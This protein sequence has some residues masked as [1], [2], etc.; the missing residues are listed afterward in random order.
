MRSLNN[1][2]CRWLNLQWLRITIGVMMLIVTGRADGSAQ[3]SSHGSQ[4]N[5]T[6]IT[7]FLSYDG[8]KRLVYLYLH[9]GLRG[10]NGGMSFN[11]THNGVQTIVIPRGWRVDAVL[12]NDDNA[13]P[14]SVIVIPDTDPIPRVATVAAFTGAASD[15]AVEGTTI[16]ERS[17]F[18]F[19]VDSSGKF[20]LLCGVP[21]HGQAGMY[22]RLLVSAVE[23]SPRVQ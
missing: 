10:D 19:T 23:R 21:G 11:G 8:P 1:C 4:S 5:S 12:A 2:L 15:N 16:G 13:L 18:T 20:L 22:V 9:A 7:D 6:R 3:D 14:H 17:R